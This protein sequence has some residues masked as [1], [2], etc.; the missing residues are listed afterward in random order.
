MRKINGNDDYYQFFGNKDNNEKQDEK[1]DNETKALEEA[2][3]IALDTRKFEIELYW[4]RAS[5]FWLFIGAVFV[6]YFSTLKSDSSL[7]WET[8]CITYLGYI[9]SVCWLCVNRGSKFW[10]ENWEKNIALLSRKMGYP[11]FELIYCGNYKSTNLRGKYPYSVSKVNQFLNCAVILF[12]A[13]LAVNRTASIAIC[14]CCE[15]PK[16]FWMLISIFVLMALFVIIHWSSKSFVSSAKKEL[17]DSTVIFYNGE[18][19]K[20]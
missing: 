6:A 18:E 16:Y 9:A 11:I 3:K 17:G 14:S 12:W 13:I 5:Y 8:I 4:K 19:S 10:Q 20:N 7:Y 15:Y 1:K 2:L